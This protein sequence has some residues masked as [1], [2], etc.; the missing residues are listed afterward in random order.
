MARSTSV[1]TSLG[2]TV[3]TSGEAGLLS[4]RISGGGGVVWFS[5]FLPVYKLYKKVACLV[6]RLGLMP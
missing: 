5:F 3:A 2:E 4:R 1:H 6:R